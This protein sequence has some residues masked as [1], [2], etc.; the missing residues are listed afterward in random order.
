MAVSPLGRIEEDRD[1]GSSCDRPGDQ[2][3]AGAEAGGG[4]HR[5][6]L[7]AFAATRVSSPLPLS[8]A[9]QRGPT[10]FTLKTPG[11]AEN[12]DT[13]P[14]TR[15]VGGVAAKTRAVVSKVPLSRRN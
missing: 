7:D 11:E 3:L 8:P 6:S 9:L 10:G 1:R 15:R 4:E 12:G 5:L 13:K 2:E 14:S